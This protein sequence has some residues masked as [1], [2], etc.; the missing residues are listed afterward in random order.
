MSFTWPG[1]AKT[2][3]NMAFDLDGQTIWR[4]KIRHL[5]NGENYLKGPSVG[6]YGPVT[7]AYRILDILKEYNIKATW[8]TPAT[9]V[10][11]N[12]ELI[13]LILAEGHELSHHGYDHTSDYGK[14]PEEQIAYLEKAQKVFEEVAGVRAVGSRH[15]GGLLPE[16]LKWMYTD[17]GYIY[18]TPGCNP[19][20]CEFFTVDGVKT[21]AVNIA[22]PEELD[23]YVMSV[24]NS[25][26]QVMVDMDPIACYKD[27][28]SKFIHECEGAVKYGLTIS[29]AFHP[30]VC[31]HPGRA[32]M[33]EDLC[34]YLSENK[35]I[36][37]ATCEDIAKYYIEHN[38]EDK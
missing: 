27:I 30:Q 5:P 34:K 6:S 4:N 8:F 20:A 24:M 2:A 33:L 21:K 38:G 11:E 19:E 13:K 12:P 31:G 35:N 3:F 16:T 9:I 28:Y 36:W 26:P 22:Q 32:Q 17:G 7:A 37:C 23:D 25:Y 15:T 1:G 18:H 10:Q 14:T 29:A